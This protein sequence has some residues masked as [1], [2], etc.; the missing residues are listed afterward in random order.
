MNSVWL[1]SSALFVQKKERAKERESGLGRFAV[2][3]PFVRGESSALREA[4]AAQIAF[5]TLPQ[6]RGSHMR[7]QPA[8]GEN[9]KELI[10]S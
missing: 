3:V 1:Y 10:M 9:G 5:V 2:M 8:C 6:V 4:F 7:V